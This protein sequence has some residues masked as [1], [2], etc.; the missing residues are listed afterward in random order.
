MTE[1]AII[2]IP[3]SLSRSGEKKRVD[4]KLALFESSVSVFEGGEEKLRL[5][6]SDISEFE[7]DTGVG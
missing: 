4:G 6:L 5:E 1:K 2:C 3:F 7:F